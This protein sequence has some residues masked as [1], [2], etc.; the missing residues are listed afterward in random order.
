MGGL[1]EDK[2]GKELLSCGVSLWWGKVETVSD[3]K[4]G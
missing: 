1:V 3:S 4:N 2:R